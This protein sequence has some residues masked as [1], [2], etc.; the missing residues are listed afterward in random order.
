MPVFRSLFSALAF[1]LLTSQAFSQP[2][3]VPDFDFSN[4]PDAKDA[5]FA[6]IP[7]S[8]AG[9]GSWQV[10]PP[11]DYWAMSGA[12]ADQWY[13]CTGVFYNDPMNKFITNASGSQCGY[14]TANIG[15]S[16]SQTLSS[17]YEVGKSY[18]LTV[19]LGGGSGRFGPMPQGTPIDIG[20]YYLDGAGSPQFV[21][22]SEVT[23]SGS[24]S[25]GYVTTLTDYSLTVPAIGMGD[26]AVG[27]NI[28][29]AI[30][31]PATAP[32]DGSY[33]DVSK[34]RLVAAVPEPASLAILSG[35]G[36][37]LFLLRRRLFAKPAATAYD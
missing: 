3:A 11:P 32:T 10:P 35:G 16:L 34:V 22:T 12:S 18:Q 23:W 17:T 31:E 4:P 13:E 28:G 15:L 24:L 26:P 8:S 7:S 37:A 25:S 5:F 1:L 29:I 21:G 14:I 33:W 6:T 20:L 27:Q 30:F 9:I 19:G 2:I 36:A